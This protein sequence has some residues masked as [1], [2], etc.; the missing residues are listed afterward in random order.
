MTDGE[1]RLQAGTLKTDRRGRVRSTV[2][3]RQAV[4]AE[5]ERSGLSGPQ[6]AR[7]AGIAYQT[8]VSWRKK[9]RAALAVVDHASPPKGTAPVRLV[10]AVLAH[11]TDGLESGPGV[12]KVDLPGGCSVRVQDSGQVSLAAQLIQALAAPC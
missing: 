12:L 1:N 10:E 9:Q 4:L 2:A 3:Q 11:R 5:F 8:F 7:V 6:F